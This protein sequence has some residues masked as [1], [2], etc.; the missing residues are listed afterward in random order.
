MSSGV[1]LGHNPKALSRVSAGQLS[2]HSSSNN[3]RR[4]FG[5]M[6]QLSREDPKRVPAATIISWNVHINSKWTRR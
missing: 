6:D 1:T 5:S 3:A 4:L 2:A